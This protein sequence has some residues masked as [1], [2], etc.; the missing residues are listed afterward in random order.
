MKKI[1]YIF[2]CIVCAGCSLNEIHELDQEFRL[3][4]QPGMYMHVS[5]A[6]VED[7]PAQQNI[8]VCAWHLPEAKD[9]V[10][11]LAGATP[12]LD[13]AE[14]HSQTM[15]EKPAAH[16]P[17]DMLWVVDDEAW[18]VDATPVAFMAYA[19]YQMPC[20]CNATDGITCHVDLQKDQT[21][22][23]YTDPHTIKQH[24]TLGWMVPL[25]FKHALAQIQFRVCHR[26]MPAEKIIV[27][28][29]TLDSLKYPGNF[30]SLREPQWTT[31]GEYAPFTYYDDQFSAGIQPKRIGKGQLVVPQKLNTRVRI[32][33]DY[34]TA[35]GNVVPIVEYTEKVTTNL[36]SSNT[37]IYTLSIGR[38]DVKFQLENIAHHFDTTE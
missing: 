24:T 12:Y 7:F 8:G 32:E 33:Y 37:Y 18:M 26:V 5:S 4:F 31:E 9:S 14:A 13:M 27:K 2:A 20:Q 11:D 28:S 35:E 36:K 29:I 15:V 16:S 30:A 6:G 3:M 34:V 21:D 25:M 23:L 19:P 22:L 10:K 1:L 17:G 38:G